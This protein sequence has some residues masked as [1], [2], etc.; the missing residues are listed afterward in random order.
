ML[1]KPPKP[2]AFPLT[3]V[4]D[5]P[6]LNCGDAVLTPYT[7]TSRRR[8]RKKRTRGWGLGVGEDL[9][10]SKLLVEYLGIRCRRDVIRSPCDRACS[11]LPAR[12]LHV[13]YI[14][15]VASWPSGLLGCNKGRAKIVS[16]GESP[17]VRGR[18]PGGRLSLDTLPEGQLGLSR[19]FPCRIL[20]KLDWE[21][22]AIVIIP[23]FPTVN[24]VPQAEVQRPALKIYDIT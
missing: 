18:E 6:G 12:L 15:V 1:T 5:W 2:V 16:S 21:V 11:W 14:T 8:K 10:N 22:R 13:Q 17:S 7:S 24:T 20:P 19:G 23:E 3:W 9:Q 4:R